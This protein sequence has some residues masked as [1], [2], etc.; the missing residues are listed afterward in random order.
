MKSMTGYGYKEGADDRLSLAVEIKG[1]N[2]RFLEVYASLPASLSQLEPRLREYVASRCVRGKVEL[3]V[4]AKDLSGSVAVSVDEAAAEAYYG[5]MKALAERLGIAEKPSL[6]SVLAM[7]GVLQAEKDRDPERAWALLEAL[8]ADAFGQFEAARVREGKAT[9]SDVLSHVAVLERGVDS[10]AAHV[11]ELEA[12]IKEGLRARF[13]EVLG[14]AVDEQRV[15]AETAVLLVKYTIS[16][17]LARLRAHLAEFRAE[18][19][20]NPAPGKKLDFLCQE[21]NRE[22]NTI[23]SKTPVL[24]VSRAVV[25]MKDA[26]ENVREQLRNVE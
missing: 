26:L 17:E 14:D 1:Y 9:E 13:R 7:E 20:R 11:P 18:A 8:L 22:V 24:D 16:E 3:S 21:I 23:G 12:S 10:V 6:A 19:A 25:E 15:L 4:R 2:N 5:A